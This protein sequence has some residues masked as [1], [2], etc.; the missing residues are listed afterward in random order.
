VAVTSNNMVCIWRRTEEEAGGDWE[1]Q[2]LQI[3]AKT[4]KCFFGQ[5]CQFG[6]T[7]PWPNSDQLQAPV[8]E[9]L[10]LLCS[11][12]HSICESLNVITV[13]AELKVFASE[14][15]STPVCSF[16]SPVSF[17]SCGIVLMLLWTTILYHLHC[18]NLPRGCIY[19]N[20][21]C[22]E[23]IWPQK[24]VQSSTNWVSTFDYLN[25]TVFILF[26]QH[27]YCTLCNM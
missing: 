5:I 15:F 1:D 8:L 14:S 9:C 13:H 24:Y 25:N 19:P 17:L 18:V 7:Q 20:N 27:S 10:D 11:F 16:S 12:V 23:P 4:K 21:C 26:H 2:C 22:Q 3:A 6:E